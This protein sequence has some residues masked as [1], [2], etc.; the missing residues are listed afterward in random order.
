MKPEAEGARK[1]TK[2][3]QYKKINDPNFPIITETRY[4]N[5]REDV[6][7]QF[8]ELTKKEEEDF[9]KKLKHPKDLKSTG[10]LPGDYFLPTKND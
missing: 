6:K 3:K 2:L 5:L 8:I 10:R 4:N 1:E 7:Q 9:W